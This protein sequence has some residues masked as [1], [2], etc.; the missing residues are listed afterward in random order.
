V[1]K[2]HIIIIELKEKSVFVADHLVKR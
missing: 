1:G 2:E